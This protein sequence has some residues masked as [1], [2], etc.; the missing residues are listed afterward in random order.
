[1][2]RARG[3]APERADSWLEGAD[4]RLERAD[5][6][7]HERNM[8]QLPRPAPF[9][10]RTRTR[11][12]DTHQKRPPCT[13]EGF[14]LPA[15][16]GTSRPHEISAC[17]KLRWAGRRTQAASTALTSSIHS[18][19]ITR[20]QPSPKPQSPKPHSTNCR[21]N[22]CRLLTLENSLSWRRPEMR[23]VDTPAQVSLNESNNQI[24]RLDV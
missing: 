2:S 7:V 15:Q 10:M 5:S 9:E 22:L 19:S 21:G 11:V 13:V 20:P 4:S 24:F 12:A 14:V 18:T 8:G 23:A 16:S 17:A 3:A 1:M 6:S